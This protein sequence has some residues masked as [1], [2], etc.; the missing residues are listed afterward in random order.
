MVRNFLG[1][2]RGILFLVAA[3]LCGGLLAVWSAVDSPSSPSGAERGQ[4][5]VATA[6]G[7][8]PRITAAPFDGAGTQAEDSGSAWVN[9]D[10]VSTPS[11]LSRHLGSNESGADDPSRTQM[12]ADA[13]NGLPWR[14]EA[15]DS[16]AQSQP[17]HQGPSHTDGTMRDPKEAS[18]KALTARSERQQ[19]EALDQ[20]TDEAPQLNKQYAIGGRVLNRAGEALAGIELIATARRLFGLPP[21]MAIPPS[22]RVHRAVSGADGGYQFQQVADG[23]YQIRTLANDGYAPAQI[24][25]RAGVDFA[26][27]VLA[28]QRVLQVTGKVAN[29]LGEPLAGVQVTPRIIGARGAYTGEAGDY[30]L[31]LEMKEN[32]GS[33]SVSF[34]RDG[35]QQQRRQLNQPRWQGAN[36][37]TV[38]VVLAPVEALAAVAG[39]VRGTTDEPVAAATVQLYSPQRKRRYRAVTD[40]AGRFVLP[41][42]EVSGDYQLVVQPQGGYREHQENNLDINAEGLQLAIRLEYEGAGTRL[43]GQMLDVEGNPIPHYN[44]TLRSKDRPWSTEV[45]S[46]AQGYYS[47]EGA[48][49]GELLFETRSLPHFTISGVR[50]SADTEQHLPLILDLGPHELRGLVVDS[51][52]YPV[53]VPAIA[54][55]WSQLNNG[56]HSR[57]SRQTAADATGQFRVTGLGAGSHMISLDAPGFQGVRLIH[58]AIKHGDQ[59]V[60]RLEEVRL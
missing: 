46:D 43:T 26:D 29:T 54:V 31:R 51:Q 18:D 49:E 41:E 47:V 1:S 39:Q 33:L 34:Q 23:E 25:V 2:S 53:A 4:G 28:G 42:V 24:T 32:A 44:L 40:D 56:V 15:R 14:D 8:G 57:A 3:G 13:M 21:G 38:D 27:L 6:P 10:G 5:V 58:D 11:A 37:T 20:E 22:E 55:S 19:I 52:G 7:S 35:Y 16:F 36:V 60:V 17:S 50:L 45:I 9:R 48:P 59:V 30:Q 12:F